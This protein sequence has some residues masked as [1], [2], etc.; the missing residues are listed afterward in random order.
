MKKSSFTGTALRVCA[1]LLALC[2]SAALLT[3]C[4]LTDL[5][6]GHGPET[7]GT[8][9]GPDTPPEGSSQ[10]GPGTGDESSAPE[11]L[12]P[13]DTG[14]GTEPPVTDT[15]PV[16]TT[17]DPKAVL[18][19]DPLT[20]QKLET[21]YSRVRPVAI[22]IDNLSS[23]APQTG[24][25][26][27]AI[28]AE[29]MVEGGISRLI[30][31]TNKYRASE[32][33]GPVRSVRDY[34]VSLS[35]AFGTLMVGAGYSPTGYTA[36]VD[37]AL[38]YIDGTHDRYALYGFFRDPVRYSQTGYEHSLMISGQGIKTL[39][40]YNNFQLTRTPSGTAFSFS[41]PDKPV[42]LSG[43]TATHCILTYS[44]FQQVQMIYSRSENVY[45]RYQY[46]TK[47]HLDAETGEQL[48]FANVFVLFAEQS[49]IPGD[50]EGRLSVS[51]TGSGTGYYLY[52]GKYSEIA[53][54]RESDVSPF[55]FTLAGGGALTVNCG[56]T[57]ISVVDSSLRGTDSVILNYKVSS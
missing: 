22:A 42:A 13:P 26:R 7:T 32:V 18:Y 15:E 47:P 27:A 23:T 12:S 24:V 10:P 37:N 36:I 52:G 54:S 48:H 14:T 45:Y 55:T 50:E 4:K 40:T 51:L 46:G 57:F 16:E 41:N 33:Y 43:G 1:V 17:R 8:A 25:G 35:A 34:M 20:G 38:D 5:L 29:V 6:F 49:R 53:W 28:L 21:D 2:L 44:V 30:L 39:A 31:I 3:G 56:K 9:A 11:T 19:T